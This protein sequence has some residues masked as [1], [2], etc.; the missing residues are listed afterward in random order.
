MSE[1]SSRLKAIGELPLVQRLH[2]A[3]AV[4]LAVFMLTLVVLREPFHGYLGEV[5]ISGPATA[6]LDLNEAVQWLK[7]VEPHLAV[8]ATP[9]GEI[10]AKAEVRAT[11]VG[12]HPRPALLHLD[13]LADR[14]LYQYLPDRLQAYRHGVLNKLRAAVAQAR[15]REDEAH[16]R[17][18]EL[19]QQ[20]LAEL[21]SG[22]AVGDIRPAVDSNPRSVTSVQSAPQATFAVAEPSSK[23]RERLETLKVQL[24]HLTGSHTEEHPE[25]VTLKSQIAAIERELAMAATPSNSSGS[26]PIGGRQTISSA[27]QAVRQTSGEATANQVHLAASAKELEPAMAAGIASAI[28]DLAQASRDR[29]A[30]EQHLT[31]RMQ[32][33]TNGPTAAQWSAAP[34]HVVTRLGGTPRSLTLALACVL[35][36][37]ASIAMFRV[38]AVELAKPRIESADDLANAVA[39][40]VVGN[41]QGNRELG[42]GNRGTA[43]VGRKWITPRRLQIATTVA[44]GFVAV[45]AGA[46]LISVAIDPSLA[47]EVLADPFGTLSEVIGR[48]GA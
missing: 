33:L 42:A 45:A 16:G 3:L 8:V 30:A 4:G 15:Q 23:L 20:Q 28:S 18:E 5:H 17:L 7:K 32:E 11:Y 35:A 46:C 12:P 13:D 26:P 31:E 47:R 6:G 19:R 29:Q 22:K 44:E 36:C 24:S 41:L 43:P 21:A 14:W 27:P 9:A 34:A 10:S 2:Q 1:P 25:I 40:P 48:F 37:V 38:T 39:L